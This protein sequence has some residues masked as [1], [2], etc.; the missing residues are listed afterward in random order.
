M[1]FWELSLFKMKRRHF[2]KT[3]FGSLLAKSVRPAGSRLREDNVW[4]SQCALWQMKYMELFW[5]LLTPR[6]SLQHE[7]PTIMISPNRVHASSLRFIYACVC[8]CLCVYS[9]V[10]LGALLIIYD[11][12]STAATS[13]ILSA[14][15]PCWGSLI[16]REE[17]SHTH[18]TSTHTQKRW[19]CR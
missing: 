14:P 17:L 18:R 7:A 3:S 8:E 12:I 9:C 4:A 19:L 2:D 10:C 5:I 1:H 16:W 6:S 15:L 13:T 11:S